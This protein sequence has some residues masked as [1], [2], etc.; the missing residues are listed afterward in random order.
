MH[1]SVMQA[2]E[3]SPDRLWR[4]DGVRW[5]ATEPGVA[6]VAF[7]PPARRRSLVA[8]A[9]GV[10]AI[11][12]GVVIIVACALPYIHYTDSQEPTTLSIF[13]SGYAAGNWFAAEPVGVAVIAIVVGI[14]LLAWSNRTARAIA[15]GVLIAY[16]VQTVLLFV[17]YV[18]LAAFS[19]SARMGPGGPVGVLAGFLLIAAGAAA[20]ASVLAGDSA[21]PV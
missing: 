7:G 6:P 14:V 2:G 20:L 10:I 18:G 12:S 21:G 15:S 5:V 1:D 17:G 4:W 9:G 11:L 13:N 16:G 8:I 19:A 3:L